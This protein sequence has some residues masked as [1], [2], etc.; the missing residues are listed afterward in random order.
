MIEMPITVP[1]DSE[2]VVQD[3]IDREIKIVEAKLEK[4]EE[5]LD[6]FEE[7]HD[8]DTDEF[9]EKFEAGD[10]GDD[11][12]WFEWKFAYKAHERLTERKKRLERA[13]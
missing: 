13:I 3:S 10:L 6:H 9:I 4:Y 11:E 1:T 5:K 7:K 8:M 2:G 12:K